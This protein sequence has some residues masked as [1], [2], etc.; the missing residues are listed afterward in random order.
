MENYNEELPN[1][2]VLHKSQSGLDLLN[3]T[4]LKKESIV[5]NFKKQTGRTHCG[6]ASLS[7]VVNAINSY[8]V[9]LSD[10][11]LSKEDYAAL[12]N[13]LNKSERL[14]LNEFDIINHGAV[15][16]YLKT[17]KLSTSGITLLEL[18]H[19][20]NLL[21]YGVNT[22]FAFNESLQMSQEKRS[23]LMKMV[24]GNSDCF[25]LQTHQ[26]FQEFISSYI[27]RSATG[28]I[29]NYDMKK[30][31][32]EL[33]GHHSPIAAI[34]ENSILVMDVW[35]DTEPAWVDSKLLFDAACSIDNESGLPRGLLHIHELL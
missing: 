35:W 22:Y 27:S 3:G 7:L 24:E 16:E 12:E 11:D 14:Y 21:G 19:I 20:T 34:N 31:G 23:E 13:K 29:V 26:E 17:T 9:K 15:K 2:M 25:I 4:N 18:K 8:R 5:N 30:L 10:P 6:P 32:Y 33:F 1:G 28:L